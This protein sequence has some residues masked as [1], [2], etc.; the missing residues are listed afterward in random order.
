VEGFARAILR[1]LTDDAL[2]RRMR[3]QGSERARQFNWE[4]TATAT[5]AVYQRAHTAAKPAIQQAAGE[6]SVEISR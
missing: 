6:Q 5:R 1:V 4:R 3:Q 2:A